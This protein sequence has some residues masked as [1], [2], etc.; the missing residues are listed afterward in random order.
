[1]D[2]RP[3]ERL[4]VHHPTCCQRVGSA[5][6]PERERLLAG[7]GDPDHSFLRGFR[8]SRNRSGRMAIRPPVQRQPFY[9]GP[10]IRDGLPGRSRRVPP[11]RGR[12]RDEHSVCG[13]LQSGYW[14]SVLHCRWTDGS[15]HCAQEGDRLRIGYGRSRQLCRCR[16]AECRKR[17]HD[18]VRG[19]E[20][21]WCVVL[22]AGCLPPFVH[23]SRP[24]LEVT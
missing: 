2:Y 16:C 22:L 9:P 18:P 21:H 17:I 14:G 1:M 8:N 19:D 15:R 11:Y 10:D 20:L 12:L 4:R 5:V 24:V 7:L 6:P 23:D 3:V 13:C